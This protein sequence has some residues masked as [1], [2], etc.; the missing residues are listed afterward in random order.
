MASIFFFTSLPLHQA[1]RLSQTALGDTAPGK[2]VNL[3]S[4][5]VNRFDIVSMFIHAMW[6]APLMTLIIG[7]LLWGEIGWAGMVGIAI[8]FVVV[9]IQCELEFF[10]DF[11]F[12]RILRLFYDQLNVLKK[13]TRF[14]LH[15][16][17]IIQVSIANRTAHG[18]T[19]QIHGRDYFGC[20]GKEFNVC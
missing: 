16:Q 11:F 19:S 10:L 3:L 2:V 13:I 12:V 20:S 7:Y 5:D 17:I 15:R 9:P 6:T 1:L 18:R 8:V 4:N 14:S